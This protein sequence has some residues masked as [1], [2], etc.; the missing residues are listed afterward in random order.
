MVTSLVRA[1]TSCYAMLIV[2][3]EVL[4]SQ[5]GRAMLCVCQQLASIVQYVERNLLLLLLAHQIYN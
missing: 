5:R 2:I 3:Q 4:L 1:M